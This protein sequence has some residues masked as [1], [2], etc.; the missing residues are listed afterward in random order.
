MLKIFGSVSGD[1]LINKKIQKLI[2]K[3]S[4]SASRAGISKGMTIIAR[5]IRKAIPPKQ[6]SVKKT[7]GQRFNK[8]KGKH[9]IDA[10]VGLGVG[11]KSKSKKERDPN[12]PGVGISKENVH[13]WELGTANRTRTTKDGRDVSTG[14]MPKGPSVVRQG[15]ESTKNEARKA[16]IATMKAKIKADA[17]KKRARARAKGK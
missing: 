6:K 8:T 16:I 14:R 15:F 1:D 11:K 17:K 7:V 9:K 2:A 3:G 5:G 4:K 13:W 10:K 12:R